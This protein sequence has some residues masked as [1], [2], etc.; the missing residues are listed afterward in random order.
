LVSLLR[1][2]GVCLCGS[3]AVCVRGSPAGRDA[4]GTGSIAGR[5]STPLS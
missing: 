5:S 4:G 3:E 1:G 2:V